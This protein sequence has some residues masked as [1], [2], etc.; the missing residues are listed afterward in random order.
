M[1]RTTPRAL[2]GVVG[3]VVNQTEEQGDTS[4]DSNGVVTGTG[5][6]KETAVSQKTGDGGKAGKEENGMQ[7]FFTKV[8]QT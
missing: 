6:S 5:S 7:T 8:S 1:G 3:G 2:D 4:G